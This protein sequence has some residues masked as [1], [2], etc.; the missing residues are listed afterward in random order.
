[1]R[2][3]TPRRA[4]TA[5]LVSFVTL[6]LLANGLIPAFSHITPTALAQTVPA[7]N[8]PTSG[9]GRVDLQEKQQVVILVGGIVDE[10]SVELGDT[11]KKGD[12]LV[13]LNT[14]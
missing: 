13:K 14:Q 6:L 11:V 10:V 2:L 8:K 12:V 1:M 4:S 9:V 5:V 3:F 7:A